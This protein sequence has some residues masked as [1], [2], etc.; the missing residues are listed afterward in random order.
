MLHSGKTSHVHYSATLGRVFTLRILALL[1]PTHPL[2][3]RG[4]CNFK[5]LHCIRGLHALC[6]VPIKAVKV[7]D[8]FH[9]TDATNIPPTECVPAP[10][11]GM[12]CPSYFQSH[13][14][15]STVSFKLSSFPS[16]TLKLF[17]NDCPVY[18]NAIYMPTV[19]HKFAVVFNSSFQTP[20]FSHP[21]HTL[22]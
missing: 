12:L 21:P 5:C 13:L 3:V 15:Q 2:G 9:L 22:S 11:F 7:C 20:F 18:H 17:S 1:N 16:L 10:S 19:E 14:S 8:L 4:K 6:V